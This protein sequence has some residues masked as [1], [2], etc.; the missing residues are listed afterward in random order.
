MLGA[1]FHQWFWWGWSLGLDVIFGARLAGRGAQLAEVEDWRGVSARV[2]GRD[3]ASV[4]R[5]EACAAFAG[6]VGLRV[7][8]RGA[9]S[10]VFWQALA[11]RRVVQAAG[12]AH[13]L[14]EAPSRPPCGAVVRAGKPVR[15]W[16]LLG[17]ARLAGLPLCRAQRR[18]WPL[19]FALGILQSAKRFALLSPRVVH[20]IDQSESAFRCLLYLFRPA[21]FDLARSWDNK[22]HD[23]IVF[24]LVSD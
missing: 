14:Q 1:F 11:R 4:V 6:P 24:L 23:I 5:R 21:S 3:G 9:N 2:T 12:A 16:P 19:E 7:S 8:V 20:L 17:R 15:A 22:F 13:A 18:V 10:G